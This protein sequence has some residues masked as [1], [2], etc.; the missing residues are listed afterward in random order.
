LYVIMEQ[1]IQALLAK[2][3]T[4]YRIIRCS[5]SSAAPHSEMQDHCHPM[6]GI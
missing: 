5:P 2:L 6:L 1:T 3:H 4:L